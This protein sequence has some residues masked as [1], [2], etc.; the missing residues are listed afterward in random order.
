[1]RQRVANADDRVAGFEADFQVDDIHSDALGGLPT[2][3]MPNLETE[4]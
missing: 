4:T 3:L 2:V 1:M